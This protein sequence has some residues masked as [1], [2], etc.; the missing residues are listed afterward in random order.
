ML[1][2]LELLTSMLEATDDSVT[3]DLAV[4]VMLDVA[5]ECFVDSAQHRM[6]LIGCGVAILRIRNRDIRDRLLA[7]LPASVREEMQ[8]GFNRVEPEA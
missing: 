6:Y 7:A 8:V 4:Q 5:R 3:A 2:A 1:Q